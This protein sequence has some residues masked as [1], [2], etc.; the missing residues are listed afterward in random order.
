MK[1]SNVIISPEEI[2]AQS[3]YDSLYDD[4]YFGDLMCRDCDLNPRN[5][6]KEC[7]AFFNWDDKRCPRHKN[8]SNFKKEVIKCVKSVIAG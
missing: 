2:V 5:E 4:A 8:W 7:V 1:K 6:D 3:M